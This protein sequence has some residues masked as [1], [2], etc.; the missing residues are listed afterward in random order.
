MLM[1]DQRFRNVAKI[2]ETPS[3]DNHCYDLENLS[4]L[5]EFGQEQKELS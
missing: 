4:L 2:I 5:R 1:Q 3:G